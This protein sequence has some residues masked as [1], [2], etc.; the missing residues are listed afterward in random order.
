MSRK[1]LLR[2]ASAI[3]MALDDVRLSDNG[4]DSNSILSSFSLLSNY[5]DDVPEPLNYLDLSSSLHQATLPESIPSIPS[6]FC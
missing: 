5:E 6:F 1:G 3:R 4:D 2:T